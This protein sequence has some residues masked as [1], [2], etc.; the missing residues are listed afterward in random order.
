MPS[1][2]QAEPATSLPQRTELGCR[3]LLWACSIVAAVALLCHLALLLWAQNAFAG[4]ESVV[5][6][7]S[8]M[9]AA[10]G[11]LYY[12]LSHYPYT[13]SA[14][15]PIFY[16]LEA[17]LSKI[18]LPAMTAGRLVSFFALLGIIALGWRLLIVYTADRYCA[19]IAALLIASTSLLGN[20]GSVGQVDTLA[21]LFALA[22]F[23]AY[24]RDLLLQAGLF[25][26]LAFF[27]KQT[28]LACSA[29]M[30]I[31]LYLDRPK[32]ALRFGAIL[33]ASV[34]VIALTIDFATG[35]RFLADTVRANLNPFALE[36][37]KPHALVLIGAS[38]MILI[39][40]I[41]MKQGWRAGRA[42]FIYL[43]CAAAVFLLT[44]AKIGSDTNYQI[45]FTILLI[46]CACV[47]LHALNFFPLSFAGSKHW[48]YAGLC[49]FRWPCTC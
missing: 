45:E 12:D 3:R 13:V 32:T 33:A 37:L 40:A 1:L 39:V 19:W 8:Q 17:G 18:G 42:F 11:T 48:I 30:F 24:S 41:G 46:L 9:L 2:V 21:V 22:A 35:G 28:M 20:W 14:Y 5:T 15:T 34:A 23:Y 49:R 6:A 44:A 4:P 38:P 16:L 43:I 29:A 27:T 7:Q 47:I 36:K 26:A 10:N 31:A 25:A